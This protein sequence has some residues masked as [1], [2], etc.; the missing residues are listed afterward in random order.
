MLAANR[1]DFRSAELP[2]HGLK[3]LGIESDRVSLFSSIDW[4][5]AF[6]NLSRNKVLR[7]VAICCGEW[8]LPRNEDAGTTFLLNYFFV[9][10]SMGIS[11]RKG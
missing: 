1:R 11:N 10:G 5:N 9:F 4:R 6:F 2:V 7:Y 3:D 8:G